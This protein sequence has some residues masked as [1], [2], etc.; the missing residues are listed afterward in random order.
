VNENFPPGGANGEKIGAQAARMQEQMRTAGESAREGA[1][2]ARD[3]AQGR[4]HEAEQ[5]A[6]EHWS[7]LQQQVEEDPQRATM[8]ALGIGFVA[9]ILLS[10]IFR[11]SR[12]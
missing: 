9:G 11:G 7:E 6:R 8:W 10:G 12:G 3:W 2:Q 1:E 5:W 4:A